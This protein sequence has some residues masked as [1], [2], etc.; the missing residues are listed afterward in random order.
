MNYEQSI[1]FTDFK[2]GKISSLNDK[3]LI[4][5][6][7]IESY[8]EII[9]ERGYYKSLRFLLQN[10]KSQV[11]GALNLTIFKGLIDNDY[12]Q[13]LNLLIKSLDSE[14]SKNLE[15]PIIFK[16]L[17]EVMFY[18][19]EF[20][21][22][23]LDRYCFLKVFKRIYLKLVKIKDINSINFKGY[24]LLQRCLSMIRNEQ[25][26]WFIVEFLIR[27]GANYTKVDDKDGNTI[28]HYLCRSIITDDNLEAFK[29]FKILNYRKLKE[30]VNITNNK[31]Y[32]PLQIA[33]M[34]KNKIMIKQ[35]LKLGADVNYICDYSVLPS[36]SSILRLATTTKDIDI[37]KMIVNHPKIN[38]NAKTG[39]TNR[40]I[41]YVAMTS[42]FYEAFEILIKK[43]AYVNAID[44]NNQSLI[45]HAWNLS[46]RAYLT[47]LVEYGHYCSYLG[48]GIYDTEDE[49]EKINL[50]L[51]NRN[52]GQDEPID[53]FNLFKNTSEKRDFN[54]KDVI[55]ELVNNKSP[56]TECI[57]NKNIKVF[58]IFIKLLNSANC[59]T[60]QNLKNNYL[61]LACEARF[62]EAIP[63]LLESGANPHY[64]DNYLY[65]H[66]KNDSDIINLLPFVIDYEKVLCKVDE[67]ILSK[68]FDREAHDVINFDNMKLS[69][70]FKNRDNIIIF[71]ENTEQLWGISRGDLFKATRTEYSEYVK[72]PLGHKVSKEETYKFDYMDFS[73]YELIRPDSSKGDSYNIRCY[74]TTDFEKYF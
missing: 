73:F 20:P 11:L 33:I 28:L 24:T 14:N 54:V 30:L 71:E 3:L 56:M 57:K 29:S 60:E 15:N 36:G 53:V 41:L 6:T 74:S 67:R 52:I 38:I 55:I 51:Q 25:P 35:L 5:D 13:C 19:L 22:E 23:T 39:N 26:N 45:F 16:I 12:F 42:S 43:G 4:C 46:D 44:I 63:I 65:N 58:I 31:G 72:L 40:S 50:V 47:K 32:S 10:F 70:F 8:L 7:N 61:K 64:K 66:F 21:G 59:E 62:L 1:Y 17:T 69:D 34:L 2:F 27:N 18:I 49:I 9:I 37:F 48:D 68:Y